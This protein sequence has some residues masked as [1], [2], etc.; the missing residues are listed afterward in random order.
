[1]S[2]DQVSPWHESRD[3]ITGPRKVDQVGIRYYQSRDY[4]GP[5]VSHMTRTGVSR[6]VRE[7]VGGPLPAD[8]SGKI[9]DRI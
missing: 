5:G 2:R 4:A 7:L 6:C 8:F 1:M 3:H 9:S